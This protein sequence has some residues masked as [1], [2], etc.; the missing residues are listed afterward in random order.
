M[1]I[2]GCSG[3]LEQSLK[4]RNRVGIWS[5]YQPAT[6]SLKSHLCGWL[7]TDNDKS[8]RNLNILAYNPVMSLHNAF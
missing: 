2:H 6:K 7:S 3:S 4:A 8:P 5:F 1:S